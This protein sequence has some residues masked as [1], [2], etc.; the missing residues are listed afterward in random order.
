M[1][2]PEGPLRQYQLPPG[3]FS[4][5]LAGGFLGHSGFGGQTLANFGFCFQHFDFPGAVEVCWFGFRGLGCLWGEGGGGREALTPRA[6]HE[7]VNILD[8]ATLD[9]R[10]V[11]AGGTHLQVDFLNPPRGK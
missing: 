9:L 5:R 1:R 8:P 4:R 7:D 3:I 11:C 6:G 2:K 10:G